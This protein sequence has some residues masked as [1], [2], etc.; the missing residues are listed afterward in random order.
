MLSAMLA[1]GQHVEQALRRMVVRTVARIEHRAIQFA[2]QQVW[3]S[4]RAVSSDDP[5][6]A[7][8]LNR[9]GGVDKGF[10]FGDAAAA[11]AE[12][13]RV[14]T[15]VA[16]RRAK[17]YFAFGCC[18]RRTDWHRSCRSAAETLRRH[19]SVISFSCWAT[20]RTVVISSAVRLSKSSK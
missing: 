16:W 2:R 18:S 1:D 17:N 15:Q 6:D 12:F 3:G 9:L 10:P 14:G 11:A 13:D 4:G 20:S 19:P 8:R 5:I 7:H